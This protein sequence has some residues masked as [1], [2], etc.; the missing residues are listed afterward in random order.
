MEGGKT[1]GN[2]RQDNIIQLSYDYYNTT[3][4]I[5]FQN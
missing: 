1:G 3:I 2:Y 5:L 4:K